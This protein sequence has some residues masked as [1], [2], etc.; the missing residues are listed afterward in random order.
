MDNVLTDYYRLPND[1][2]SLPISESSSGE[3]GFFKFGPKIVCYGNSSLGVAEQAERADLFDAAKGVAVEGS[4]VRLPFSVPQVIENLRREHY[5]KQWNPDRNKIVNHPVTRNAYYVV[6]DLLPVVMR[7]YLQRSYFYNWQALPF[8]SW[9]VDSS[10][11]AL[12]EAY[13]R[14][15]MEAK[16]LQKV[17]FIWFWPN[18]APNSVILTH[19]VETLSGRNFTSTLMDIDESQGFRA[20]IQVVPE[21]R[22]DVPDEYVSF[23]RERGFEFNVHDLNHD[24]NL[25]RDRDEFRR[26]AQK[27]NEYVRKYECQGF[28]SGAMYRNVDWYDAF[29]FSY[30]MSVPNV[31]HLEPQR[32]GCC[33]VMPYFIG[34]I[35]EIPLT[36]C[37]DYSLFQILNDYSL[38]IWKEQIDLIRAKYGL[39]SFIA[40]PDYLIDMKSRKT[41]EKLLV[42]LRQMVDREKIWVALPGEID[43]WWRARSRMKLVKGANDWE[44]EGEGKEQARIAYAVLHGNRLSYEVSST[45]VTE[46]VGL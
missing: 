4:R 23:I 30:D 27:I 24:G 7:R 44:I 37:Q 41:Y 18:G 12:H 43:R 40:H 17:P 42:Y 39:M 15:W 34:N 8:P 46:S 31:A 14:L 28:R 33:T 6:R 11:D 29:E 26:R 10:V 19:D 45:R 9:P 3:V 25:Y 35:L 38:G 1:W 5:V 22:Y 13:L 21:K 16:G 20:S 36:T 2:E 32:G